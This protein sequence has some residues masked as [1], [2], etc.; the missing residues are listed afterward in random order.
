MPLQGYST[1]PAGPKIFRYN[2]GKYISYDKMSV[3]FSI[4]R[5]LDDI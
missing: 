3:L 1:A 2:S 5:N 4:F